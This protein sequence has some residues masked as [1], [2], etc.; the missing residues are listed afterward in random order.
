M[1][2]D[3]RSYS[4]TISL[5]II[6]THSKTDFKVA[7]LVL[8]GHLRLTTH[9]KL[10]FSSINF[11]PFFTE[12]QVEIQLKNKKYIKKQGLPLLKKQHYVKTEKLISKETVTAAPPAL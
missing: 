9:Q 6:T 1:P 3:M 5:W 7:S 8:P 12:P 10:H 4:V 2:L 11:L